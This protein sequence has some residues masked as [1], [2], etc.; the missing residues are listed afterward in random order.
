MPASAD[1]TRLLEH[2]SG[3]DRDAFDALL[4]LL[5]DQLRE[6]ARG[7][8]RREHD[9]SI[10]TTA[11]VHETYLRM[12]DL[13]R[14][15]WKDRAHF[16]AM[17]SRLMRRIL[18]DHWRKKHAQ[19]RGGSHHRVPLDEH[20]LQAEMRA[21]TLLDLDEALSRFEKL[22]P[23]ACL[24]LEH[25]YFGGL[26]AKESAAVLGVSRA[27]VERDLRAARAWLAREWAPEPLTGPAPDPAP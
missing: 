25:R 12:V 20:Q 26:T 4:P 7:R 10:N 16:L 9:V 17:A 18:V 27:T 8:L 19:K 6:L 24:A 5:Y 11:L 1:V 23:R 13:D 15:Q 22:S 21:E 3:G 2:W 14:I